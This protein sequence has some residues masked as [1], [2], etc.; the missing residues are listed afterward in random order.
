M[1]ACAGLRDPSEG[2][3]ADVLHG[4]PGPGARDR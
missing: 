1:H 4:V 3:E 2:I